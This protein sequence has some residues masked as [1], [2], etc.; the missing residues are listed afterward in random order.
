MV[1]YSIL[2]IGVSIVFG[3]EVAN[4][5]AT[6]AIANILFFIIFLLFSLSFLGAFE[7]DL[8]SSLVNK[9]NKKSNKG[10]IYGI[11]FIEFT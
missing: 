5:L 7:I 9:V 4:D 3:A 6:S 1:I 10:G 8:P 2:G 11:F